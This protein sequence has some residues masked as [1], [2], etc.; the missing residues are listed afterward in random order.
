[1]REDYKK[2]VKFMTT[3]DDNYIIPEE[4]IMKITPT[5]TLPFPGPVPKLNLVRRFMEHFGQLTPA[6]VTI[7]S[8][9]TRSARSDMMSEET[10]EYYLAVDKV[11]VLDAIC[12]LLYVT[13]GA[14]V[15][16]GFKQ[17]AIDEAFLEVHRS[18][19]SKLWTEKEKQQY[20]SDYDKM[21]AREPE[22]T[23]EARF[24]KWIAKRKG[25]VIKSP[26]Y[27]PAALER[28]CQ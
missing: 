25:K 26:S 3:I 13:Y 9:L 17:E 27:S 12:D 20:E 5:T 16:A 2:L 10:A 1:M 4:Y 18:N 28:W 11:A 8:H 22:V 23:F 7:P 24:D 15:E 6:T 19:M 14:A 21:L